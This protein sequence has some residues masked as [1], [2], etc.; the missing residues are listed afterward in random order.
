MDES[1]VDTKECFDSLK[2][3]YNNTDYGSIKI[4]EDILYY[5]GYLTRYISYTRNISSKYLYKN[6]SI[7]MIIDNYEI[8]HTQSEEW[9]IKR[10]QKKVFNRLLSAKEI[11]LRLW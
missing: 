9:V 10:I 3:Q 2:E 8:Y 4:N 11:L 1:E 5:V 6:Y 7:D